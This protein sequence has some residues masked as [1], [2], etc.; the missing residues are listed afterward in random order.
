MPENNFRMLLL[1]LTK[2]SAEII[3][4]Y[5][6]IWTAYQIQVFASHSVVR[7][8]KHSADVRASAEI[9][10]GRVLY[11][12]MGE[13]SMA[14]SS[15]RN[16]GTHLYHATANS[17]IQF[18]YYQPQ[19]YPRASN[20]WPR[21]PQA[22][23]GQNQRWTMANCSYYPQNFSHLGAAAVS[24]RCR[25]YMLLMKFFA[26]CTSIVGAWQPGRIPSRDIP[27]TEKVFSFM[28]LFFRFYWSEWIS[29]MQIGYKLI[30]ASW[31]QLLSIWCIVLMIFLQ[32]SCCQFRG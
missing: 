9:V 27:P 18:C 15:A 11:N 5:L 3:S 14:C 16:N 24:A 28:W 31:L 21:H 29:V 17:V 25:V 4:W 1:S 6:A 32:R 23:F 22:G 30:L 7:I 8:E 19:W 2:H 12:S 20:I 13:Y 26:D 10:S